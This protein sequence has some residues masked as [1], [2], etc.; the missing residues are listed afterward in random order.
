MV[1]GATATVAI[2]VI[3]TS[4][5]AASWARKDDADQEYSTAERRLSA[6]ATSDTVASADRSR[7]QLANDSTD[8]HG[9]DQDEP[10]R[11][12]EFNLRPVRGA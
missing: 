7:R 6:Q 8:P 11:A 10:D 1:T 3:V 9:I 2:G 12:V 4:V 5:S